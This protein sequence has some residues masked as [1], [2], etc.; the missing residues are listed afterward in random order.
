M[1]K[2][3]GPMSYYRNG[4]V[5]TFWVGGRGVLVCVEAGRADAGQR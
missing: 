1:A 5:G 4:A 3:D 2:Y